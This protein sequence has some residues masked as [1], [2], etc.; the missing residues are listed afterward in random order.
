MK[1][2]ARAGMNRPDLLDS[3]MAKQDDYDDAS[4]MSTSVRTQEVK[5]SDDASLMSWSVRTQEKKESGFDG[6]SRVSTHGMK[7]IARAGMNRPDLLDSSMAKQD[8]YDET[9]LMSWSVR[10]QEKKESG[11]DGASRVSTHGMK[12]IARADFGSSCK[13]M[14]RA[15]QTFTPRQHQSTQR[16]SSSEVNKKRARFDSQEG[17]T[18]PPTLPS[19]ESVASV[20][21]IPVDMKIVEVLLSRHVFSDM[22]R[23]S[24]SNVLSSADLEKAAMVDDATQAMAGIDVSQ[25]CHSQQDS[26]VASVDAAKE[27]NRISIQKMTQ[28]FNQAAILHGIDK[29]K[30]SNARKWAEVQQKVAKE[31]E[32]EAVVSAQKMKMVEKVL[33]E[34]IHTMGLLDALAKFADAGLKS[35][36]EVLQM[37]LEYP[38]SDDDTRDLIQR[39]LSKRHPRKDRDDNSEQASRV[40]SIFENLRLD[41]SQ[42]SQASTTNLP[43]NHIQFASRDGDNDEVSV[44]S[45]NTAGNSN[46]MRSDNP[47]QTRA[48]TVLPRVEEATDNGEDQQEEVIV[49]DASDDGNEGNN[50]LRSSTSTSNRARAQNESWMEPLGNSKQA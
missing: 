48:G 5:E 27:A 26:N 34:R 35:S 1:G 19:I 15:K 4:L 13:P 7:G 22:K 17:T 12:G 42:S 49:E 30:A 45:G 11:F 47:S 23:C 32:E 18:T 38:L 16:S 29:Q 44:I 33:N 2:I 14:A 41:S 43:F 24:I 10:T 6:A 40:A 36:D 8:D 25:L 28:L 31:A 46:L 3:S 20:Y 37:V 9:S 39:T 50:N 21:P